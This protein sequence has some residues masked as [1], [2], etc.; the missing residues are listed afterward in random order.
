MLRDSGLRLSF[1]SFSSLLPMKQLFSRQLSLPKTCAFFH[2]NE[3]LSPTVLDLDGCFSSEKPY[4]DQ[5]D[6]LVCKRAL[7]LLLMVAAK[8]QQANCANKCENGRPKRSETDRQSQSK[9]CENKRRSV[10]EKLPVQYW[11]EEMWPKFSTSTA[12]NLGEFSGMF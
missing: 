9:K 10:P 5:G 2:S 7:W 12:N 3:L 6:S 1:C 4:H 8:W 11:K